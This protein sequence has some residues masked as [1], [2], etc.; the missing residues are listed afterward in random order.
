MLNCPWQVL[1]S[2]PVASV[3]PTVG[4]RGLYQPRPVQDKLQSTVAMVPGPTAN[5]EHH[6]QL[7][8]KEQAP[9]PV[10]NKPPARQM[11]QQDREPLG[12]GG[13]VTDPQRFW[14]MRTATKY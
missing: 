9:W 13:E 14:N 6:R 1:N 8:E 10:G 11:S 5:R 7:C 3:S 4:I 2:S 12:T